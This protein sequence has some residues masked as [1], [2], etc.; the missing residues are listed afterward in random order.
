MRK[1]D[2]W[3][4]FDWDP[5]PSEL[6]RS[7]FIEAAKWWQSRDKAR[8]SEL[9][10]SFFKRLDQC[11]PLYSVADSYFRALPNG[12]KFLFALS[13]RATVIQAMVEIRTL[14]YVLEKTSLEELNALE[15]SRLQEDGL[16]TYCEAALKLRDAAKLVGLPLD[17][18]LRIPTMEHPQGIPPEFHQP[19]SALFN[20]QEP[21]EQRADRQLMCDAIAIHDNLEDLMA[22]TAKR[23]KR[24]E[25]AYLI[26]Q[27]RRKLRAYRV[28]I[29]S[30]EKPHATI[31]ELLLLTGITVGDTDVRDALRDR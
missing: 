14:D 18:Y 23:G 2:N 4:R 29:D 11:D 30:I 21:P 27:F 31:A 17:F 1:D 8:R 15:K 12:Q 24:S 6:P 7:D 28:D 25:K 20:Y 13:F 26:R 5:I 9:R 3:P 22:G 16:E 10:L 19:E